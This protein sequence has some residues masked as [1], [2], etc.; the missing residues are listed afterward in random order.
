VG[1]ARTFLSGSR[2]RKAR[3]WKTAN[4]VSPTV[5]LADKAASWGRIILPRYL[6][7]CRRNGSSMTNR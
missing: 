5:E 7:L 2:E 6:P 4:P 1:R 3:L